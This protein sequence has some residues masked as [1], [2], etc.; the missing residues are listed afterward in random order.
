MRGKFGDTEDVIIED[1]SLREEVLKS[2]RSKQQELTGMTGHILLAMSFGTLAPMILVVAPLVSWLNLRALEWVASH[3]K[4]RRFGVAIA[5]QILVH[6]PFVLFRN[7]GFG[8]II[9]TSIFVFHDMVF[10]PHLI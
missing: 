8:L 2:T 1:L 5:E 9:G 10:I 6:T 4:Q 3:S 7:L